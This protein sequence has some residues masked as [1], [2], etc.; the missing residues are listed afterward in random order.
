MEKRTNPVMSNAR[1]QEEDKIV[2][3]KSRGAVA[4]GS[5]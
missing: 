1:M 4:P 5:S 3:K 2:K